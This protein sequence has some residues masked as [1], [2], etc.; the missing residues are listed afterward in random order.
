MDP[1]EQL[2]AKIQQLAQQAE[3]FAALLQK[4]QESGNVVESE[5]N[6]ILAA[7]QGWKGAVGGNT[8]AS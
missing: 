8:E 5:V 3:G 1:L 7:W 6:E 2:V 4:I